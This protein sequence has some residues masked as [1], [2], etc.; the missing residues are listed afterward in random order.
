MKLGKRKSIDEVHQLSVQEFTDWIR[1]AND[2]ELRE[3]NVD[4]RFQAGTTGW[5][6]QQELQARAVRRGHWTLTPAFVIGF[7]TMIF[8][9]IAAWPIVRDWIST[10]VAKKDVQSE[11]VPV[12]QITTTPSPA[13]V[14]PIVSSPT[15]VQMTPSPSATPK[16]A[17]RTKARKKL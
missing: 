11:F 10:P 17:R 13:L 3:I 5:I 8:A 15:P 16:P 6:I 12:P 4:T 7:L 1:T 9:A 2:K 14:L